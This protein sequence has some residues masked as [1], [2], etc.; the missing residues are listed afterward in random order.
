MKPA[1]NCDDNIFG[2]PNA[3]LELVEYGDCECPYCGLAH[4][5]IKCD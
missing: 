4:P 1:V 5:I 3:R 2:N